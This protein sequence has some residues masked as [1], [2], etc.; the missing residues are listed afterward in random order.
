LVDGHLLVALCADATAITRTTHCPH[1]CLRWSWFVSHIYGHP[2]RSSFK[3]TFFYCLSSGCDA[4]A[5]PRFAVSSNCVSVAMSLICV[6]GKVTWLCV[7]GSELPF[8]LADGLSSQ[9]LAQS[10]VV[11]IDFI[12]DWRIDRTHSVVR[13]RVLC[14]GAE[15]ELTELRRSLYGNLISGPIP[16]SIG[17]L[18]VLTH[19]YVDMLTIQCPQALLAGIFTTTS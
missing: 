1:E 14:F 16:S 2:S 17:Q 11:W 5:C 7:L 18:V 13:C 6:G 19:L 15:S 8:L 9:E 12:V 3:I 10:P 4:T